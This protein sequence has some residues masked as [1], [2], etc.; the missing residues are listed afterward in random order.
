MAIQGNIGI[1]PIDIDIIDTVLV[2]VEGA[3]DRIAIGAATVHNTTGAT[4]TISLYDSPD[5]TS[6]SG[7]E[8]HVFSVAAG[9]LADV[10]ALIHGY[11]SGRYIVGVAS[12][13]GTNIKITY[14]IYTGGS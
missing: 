3:V 2:S 10:S 4:I 8:I 1:N 5:A 13:V 11:G 7:K 6:A 14:T 9:R 12:A